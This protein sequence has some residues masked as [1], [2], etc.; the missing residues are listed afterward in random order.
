MSFIGVNVGYNDSVERARSFINKTGMSYP[1]L[2]D[3]KSTIARKYQVQGVPT[4]IIAD[5]KGKVVYK[6]YGVP[7]LSEESFSQLTL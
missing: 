1:V 2:F 5:K 4:I 3:K 7:E 6:N